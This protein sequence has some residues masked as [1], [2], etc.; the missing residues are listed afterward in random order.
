ML[1]N[2]IHVNS[3]GGQP[4]G[5]SFAFGFA[6]HIVFCS[7]VS[8]LPGGGI[9]IPLHTVGAEFD[10]AE[11]IDIESLCVAFQIDPRNAIVSVE[12]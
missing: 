11:R 9:K 6:H 3:L 4:T 5:A 10:A 8:Q 2:Q 12:L 7:K 1:A